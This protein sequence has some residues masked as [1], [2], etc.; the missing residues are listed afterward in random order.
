[1]CISAFVSST[2]LV[3]TISFFVLLG[4]TALNETAR[5]L[6]NPFGLDAN[7]LALTGYQKDFNCKLAQLPDLTIPELGYGCHTD[8]TKNPLS[9]A[10]DTRDS[11]SAVNFELP[12]DEAAS[13]RTPPVGNGRQRGSVVA[14]PGAGG[15]SPFMHMRKSSV[16]GLHDAPSPAAPLHIEGYEEDA[17]TGADAA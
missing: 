16:V 6:E 4:Y 3:A 9:A 10:Y 11:S 7:D 13:T 1:M 15:L 5:E 14:A 12:G 17:T 8:Y 2:P